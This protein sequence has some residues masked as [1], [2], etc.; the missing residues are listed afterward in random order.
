MMF[1]NT[2]GKVEDLPPAIQA[3][4]ID[5]AVETAEGE[6][7]FLRLVPMPEIDGLDRL[8]LFIEKGIN[9]HIL[10]SAARVVAGRQW[11]FHD[12]Y[13]SWMALEPPLP[14]RINNEAGEPVPDDPDTP[15]S[16][17]WVG[18]VTPEIYDQQLQH[19]QSLE[20][21]PPAD[22]V[23]S[24]LAEVN[25]H[26]RLRDNGRYQPITV[27]GLTYDADPESVKNI[28]GAVREWDALIADDQLIFAGLVVDGQMA[29][30]ME[31]NTTHLVTKAMLREV[32]NALSVRASLLHAQYVR[33]K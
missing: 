22:T 25:Y 19:W 11:A 4:Y 2:I 23:D 30:T 29:W 33:T 24:V 16:E 21:S 3:F 7:Y 15:L 8:A 12:K 1:D 9:D 6:Q 14:Q 28:E 13:L 26:K 5:E 17:S 10:A 31:D 18:G 20:P 27:N 32:L